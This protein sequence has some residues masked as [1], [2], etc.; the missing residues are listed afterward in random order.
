MKMKKVIYFS[1]AS[2]V[3]LLAGCTDKRDID[4]ET[5]DGK[6][7]EFVHFENAGDEWV[8]SETDES[9]DYDVNV[10][11]TYK[12][13]KDV[14]Y[15]VTVGKATTGV[16]GKDFSIPN[17]SVTIKAGQYIGSVPVKILY[18]T[19]GEG[20]VLELV[21]NVEDNLINP[22]YGAASTISVATD[23][24]TIDW[25]WLAGKWSAQDTEGDPYSM[26]ITQKEGDE[27]IAIF[28]NLWGMGADMEGK[29]DFDA[30]TVAFKGPI[31][32]GEIYGGH[33]FV[34]HIDEATDKYDD[35]YFYATLT[36]LGITITGMGYYLVG[37]AYDGYDFGADTTKMTR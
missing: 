14:T 4:I 31:D 35:G 12:Y 20:F 29:V 10:A 15:N 13:D 11:C 21:L 18:D 22:V 8:I 33:L 32:L 6:G 19:V 37:G 2:L 16:E 30:K 5:Y 28:T 1:I 17:K 36:P 25:E 27:T 9:F 24:V 26:T 23:K 7:L 34:A 3:L